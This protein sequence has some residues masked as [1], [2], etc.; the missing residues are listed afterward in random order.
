MLLPVAKT[1]G[2][3]A[4][5][6]NANAAIQVLGGAG[7]VR[8]W[9]VE[10][11]L[12]DC[13]VFSI[14]EGTTAIQG[15]DLLLRRVLGE[16]GAPVLRGLLDQLAPASGIAEAVLGSA[17]ALAE[18]APRLREAAAVPF[19]QL[20]ALACADGLLRRAG[21]QAGPF[22]ARYTA[23]AAF[24]GAE[25]GERA[26]LLAARCRRG[27]LDTAFDAVFLDEDKGAPP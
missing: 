24:H 17:A 26:A 7:Y 1:L 11:L 25:V 3:E 5:F 12:R 13:R 21:H 22:A 9:P 4:A 23:L 6:A 14:Y 19:L 2:A 8:D 18:A 10:R 16:A 27:D 20:L 15:L